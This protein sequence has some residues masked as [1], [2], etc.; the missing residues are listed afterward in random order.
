MPPPNLNARGDAYRYVPPQPSD[1]DDLGG[2]EPHAC[3]RDALDHLGLWE[4]PWMRSEL[5]TFTG[6]V[7]WDD[8]FSVWDRLTDDG[9]HRAS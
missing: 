2:Y 1:A 5:E 9:M 6:G 7:A 3:L 8:R 4:L